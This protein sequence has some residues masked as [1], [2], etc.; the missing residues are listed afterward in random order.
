MIYLEIAWALGI[1]AFAMLDLA[2]AKGTPKAEGTLTATL[3]RWLGIQPKRWWRPIGMV[4]AGGFSVWFFGH[5]AFNWP[6]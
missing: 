1:I 3:R 5:I 4:I 2:L 6:P